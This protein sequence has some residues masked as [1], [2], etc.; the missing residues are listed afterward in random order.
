MELYGVASSRARRALWTLEEI[1]AEFTF[2]RIDMRKGEH[3]QPAFLAI[4]P[5][6]KVPVLVDGDLTL[7]ESGAIC[8]HIALC[9]PDANLLPEPGSRNAALCQQWIFWVI[10]E[11]EQPLWNMAKHKFILPKELRL[12]AMSD[13]AAYEWQRPS[14]ILAEHLA[15][16]EYM[17]GDTFTLADIFVGH[18]LN[19]ARD[20]KVDLGGDVTNDYLD[21]MIARPAF[22]R[23]LDY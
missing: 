14:E 20:V 9:H 22:K 4:N 1:G 13:V 16:R 23:T 5:N 6:G 18:T 19:W 10:S 3:R 15:G 17:V 21:R 2:H 8:N 7:F 11:L 12:A